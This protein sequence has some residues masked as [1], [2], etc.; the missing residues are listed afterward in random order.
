M[1][2]FIISL[3]LIGAISVGHSQIKKEIVLEPVE[4][5]ANVVNPEYLQVV[6]N[7]LVP[8]EVLKFQK[9]VAT[10]D[11]KKLTDYDKNSKYEVVFKTTKGDITTFYNGDG[12]IVW[13]VGKYKSVRPPVDIV[14]RVMEENQGWKILDDKYATTY[15]G[16]SNS[17]KNLYSFY[18][19]NG[20]SDKK[21]KLNLE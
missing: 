18:L 5:T 19:S 2:T 4:L 7:D 10:F 21:V 12:K 15:K 3:F 6:Q 13:S 1:K 14:K 20:S 9:R 11:I 16:S 8:L 17:S